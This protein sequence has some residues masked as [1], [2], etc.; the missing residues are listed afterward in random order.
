MLPGRREDVYYLF[1]QFPSS[2]P[3]YRQAGLPALLRRSGYATA[4]RLSFSGGARQAKKNFKMS[5]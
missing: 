2:R 1:S 5:A 3:A 4:C